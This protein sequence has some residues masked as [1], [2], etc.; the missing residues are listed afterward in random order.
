MNGLEEASGEPRRGNGPSPA[1]SGD[2]PVG[3]PS[4][5]ADQSRS[6]RLSVTGRYA[7]IARPNHWFK[8]A[9]M[10]AG[11]VLGYFYYPGLLPACN[12]WMLLWAFAAT[13]LIASSN[14]VINEILDAP[15]DRNHPRK[16]HRPIAS[17]SVRLRWAYL[18]WVLLAIVGG[19][20][21]YAVN[22]AFFVAG[23]IFLAMG[24][25]YNVPPV[26]LKELPYIDVLS[27]S[28]NTPIR[29]ALGWFTVSG[30]TIPPASLLISA[31]LTGAFF[32]A[33][34]RFAEYRSIADPEA[35][36]AYRA[37]FRHYDESKLLVSMFFYAT[38]AALFLGVFIIRYHL[39]LILS[40]PLIA[41]FFSW[42]LRV[43]L[44]QDSPVQAPEGLYR[45][46][47]LMVY[48]LLCVALFLGLMFVR[49]SVLY[50]W[51]NV[52]PSS[53]PSLWEF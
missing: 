18:E 41:G 50:E 7:A 4:P 9:F 21:A 36:S 6:P 53:V 1:S 27:E 19:A 43:A 34:K 42:Y 22:F 45:E 25:A 40:I 31:W 23:A 5:A 14:Y 3:E 26:R 47:G 46:R 32:M 2:V 52:E 51:F 44:K 38:A 20:M 13:C 30:A 33:T 49:V 16:R 15:R 28:M 8:N 10:L 17:G 29:L 35:A 24:L 11:I 39:E 48:L 12:G 37:S